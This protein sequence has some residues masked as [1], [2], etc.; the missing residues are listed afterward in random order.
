MLRA[1]MK[2]YRPILI[3]RDREKAFDYYKKLGF[4]CNHY[5]GFMD[6]DDLKLTLHQ[7]EDETKLIVPNHTIDGWSWDIYVF[8][9]DADALYREYVECGAII[10][11]APKDPIEYRMREFAIRD[12]DGYILAFASSRM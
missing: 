7:L 9:D 5:T 2:E 1:K 6:R 3:S 12:L 10:H 8:V 4:E 11:Y